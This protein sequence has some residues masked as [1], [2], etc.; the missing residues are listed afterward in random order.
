MIMGFA[1]APDRRSRILIGVSLAFDVA[2]LGLA[3]TRTSAIALVTA[4]LATIALM[5]R[6]KQS[7]AALMAV[8]L[9]VLVILLATQI[10]GMGSHVLARTQRDLDAG[11]E[12]GRPAVWREA[13]YAFTASPLVGSGL[14]ASHSYILGAARTMGLAFLL[15]L[16]AAMLIIWSHCAWLRK[17]RYDQE[18]YAI[19]G[20]VMATLIVVFFLNS[21]GTMLRGYPSF[22]FWIIIGVAESVY[23]DVRAK[24]A[25]AARASEPQPESLPGG[26]RAEL[27]G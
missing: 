26:V 12:G 18:S 3:G 1:Y 10:S 21:T 16:F 13:F 4:P 19:A 23:L 17:I 14:G 7:R 27:S 22:V 20:G 6:S 9:I 8:P 11:F 15:P 24:R 5:P 25:L 2:W